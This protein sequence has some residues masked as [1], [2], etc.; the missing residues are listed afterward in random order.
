MIFDPAGPSQAPRGDGRGGGAPAP[1]A[2]SKRPWYLRRNWL[3]TGAVVLVAVVTVVTDLPTHASLGSQ[4][5]AD[6]S[7]IKTVNSDVASCAYAVHEGF[8]IWHDDV[9][10][11]LT[12][13]DRRL[14]PT[15]LTQDQEACSFTSETIYNLSTI[16]APGSTSGHDVQDL[17]GT[18]TTW[19][20]SDAVLALQA[21]Q[22]LYKNP[23]S[24]TAAARLARAERELAS[25]K[26]HA[27]AEVRAAEAI[28]HLSLPLPKLPNL[29]G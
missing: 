26:R 20:T 16:D 13:A 18:V 12:A 10:H 24:S 22:E 23:S 6:S 19:A 3:L 27:I 25:D 15:L 29:P 1:P 11:S 9:T 21:V 7:V 2:P 14:V 8:I 4:A 17:I 5:A 28:V